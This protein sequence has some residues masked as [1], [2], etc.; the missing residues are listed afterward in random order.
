MR[1]EHW[2]VVTSSHVKRQAPLLQA[3]VQAH[4]HICKAILR[5]ADEDLVQCYSECALN[6]LKG[7]VPL[8]GPQKAKLTKYKQKLRKVAN[9][10]ISLKEKHKI[11][12]TG[13]FVPLLLAPLLG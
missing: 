2:N 6:M 13:G 5:G 3:L 10:K 7:N 4:P 1:R 9:K 8:S 12:Q 11:V